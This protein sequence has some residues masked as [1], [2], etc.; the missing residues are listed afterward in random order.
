MTVMIQPYCHMP[1][2][3]KIIEPVLGDIKI[4]FKIKKEAQAANNLLDG[5]N[6]VPEFHTVPD[7]TIQTSAVLVFDQVPPATMA[8]AQS[9]DSVLGL[10]IPLLE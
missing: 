6:N 5:E 8:R 1:P 7:L 4:P 10:V 9:K 2:N 3:Y